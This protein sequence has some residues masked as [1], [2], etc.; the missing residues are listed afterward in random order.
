M[1]IKIDKTQ[2]EAA[3]QAHLDESVRKG[4]DYRVT[5]ALNSAIADAIT[6]EIVSGY[7]DAAMQAL[8]DP[9]VTQRIV[10]EMQH[11]IAEGVRMTLQEAIVSVAGR[12]RGYSPNRNR[13]DEQR[14]EELR[15]RLFPT[16][17]VA[18]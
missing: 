9:A 8:T 4:I 17:V 2:I 1:E 16:Q 18:S 3:I 12:L 5:Q 10:T 15:R 11:A 13:E 14:L 6:P 7:V